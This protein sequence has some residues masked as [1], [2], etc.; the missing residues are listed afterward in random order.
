[1]RIAP[2]ILALAA[3]AACANGVQKMPD[4]KLP[5]CATLSECKAHDGKRVHVVGVYTIYNVM[6][7]RPLDRETAPVRIAFG[8]VGPGPG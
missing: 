8:D 5:T 4:D 3:W 7:A 1:M 2:S 6:P